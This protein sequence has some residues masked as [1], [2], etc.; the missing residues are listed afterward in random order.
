MARK[1]APLRPEELTR[2][3]AEQAANG[4]TQE[5][6]IYR[7]LKKNLIALQKGVACSRDAELLCVFYD[8]NK[9]QALEDAKKL[10][11]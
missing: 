4:G 11:L 8:T 9:T 1:K 6:W 2:R 10:T 5:W 3:K 7:D